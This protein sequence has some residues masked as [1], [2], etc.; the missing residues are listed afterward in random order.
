[1]FG[2]QPRRR[3]LRPNVISLPQLSEDQLYQLHELMTVTR[4][5]YDPEK[6]QAQPPGGNQTVNEAVEDALDRT[7]KADEGGEGEGDGK[8]R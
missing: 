1:M 7:R 6:A 3:L 4:E 8:G 2:R 5:M